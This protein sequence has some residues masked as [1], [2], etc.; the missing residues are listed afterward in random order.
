MS[1]TRLS[2]DDVSGGGVTQ[3]PSHPSLRRGAFTPFL[4]EQ[5]VVSKDIIRSSCRSG[6]DSGLLKMPGHV[7]I[8]FAFFPC[9][10]VVR[11]GR[12]GQALSERE[13]WLS[14]WALGL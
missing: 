14:D 12:R 2:V 8:C 6:Q 11:N 9:V 3:E 10:V 7:G 5:A 13:L 1:L 4:S